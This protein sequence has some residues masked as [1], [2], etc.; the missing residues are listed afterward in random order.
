MNILIAAAGI[1]LW[2]AVCVALIVLI[3]E[4]TK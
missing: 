2:V 3:Q 1:G 4:L